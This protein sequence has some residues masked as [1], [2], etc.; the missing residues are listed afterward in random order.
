M[1]NNIFTKG[2]SRA[3]SL[4]LPPIA[5]F[6]PF[7]SATKRKG[8]S[9]FIGNGRRALTQLRRAIASWRLFELS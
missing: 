6:G 4:S 3:I 8:R 1:K 2:K 7:G 9:W 5:D